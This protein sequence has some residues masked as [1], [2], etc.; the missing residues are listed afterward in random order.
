MSAEFVIGRL[1]GIMQYEKLKNYERYWRANQS[2]E[3]RIMSMKSAETSVTPQAGD[4]S[5]HMGA[6]DPMQS[7]DKRIDYCASHSEEY[8]QNLAVMHEVD[9][10][11][12]SLKD[13]LEREILRLRY[14]DFRYGQQMSWSQ[15][16]DA[17]YGKTRVSRTTVYKLHDDAVHHF[18]GSGQDCT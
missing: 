18:C 6:H 15:V 8:A 12:A 9:K 3:Q 11:I 4:G 1:S 10:V 2:I 16:K 5:Q 17:L 14:T 7:V 13:P